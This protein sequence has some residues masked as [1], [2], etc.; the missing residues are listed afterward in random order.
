MYET[1]T[2]K[3]PYCFSKPLIFSS[4]RCCAVKFLGMAS[5]RPDGV[6]FAAFE[7]SDVSVRLTGISHVRRDLQSNEGRSRNE[8]EFNYGMNFKIRPKSVTDPMIV[9][10]RHENFN[11]LLRHNAQKNVHCAVHVHDI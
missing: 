10:S 7:S 2:Y 3:R 5:V 4:S 8:S 1:A 9:Y 11:D 6:G